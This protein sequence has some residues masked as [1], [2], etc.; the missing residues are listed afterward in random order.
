LL[1]QINPHFLFN[2]F[3]VLQA[4]VR[5]KDTRTEEFVL[6]LE[7]VFKQTLKTEKG[8]VTLQEELDFFNSYM[9]LMDLRQENAF[10]VDIQVAEEALAYRLPSFALQLLAENCIKHN[11][12]SASRPLSIRLYQKDP[13]SLTIANNYQPKSAA[14]ESFGIGIE[15]IKKRYRL[16]GVQQGVLIEQNETTYSTTIKLF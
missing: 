12:A 9:Y 1:Q 16:E 15:N 10:V 4:M 11:V 8:T 14:I 2:S 13:K 3:T 7:D 6:K 5:S